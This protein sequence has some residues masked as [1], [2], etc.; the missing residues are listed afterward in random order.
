MVDNVFTVYAKY[1]ERYAAVDYLARIITSRE[2]E[3]QVSIVSHNQGYIQDAM[4]PLTV[5]MVKINQVES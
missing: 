2:T 5:D 3:Q 4:Y 1:T